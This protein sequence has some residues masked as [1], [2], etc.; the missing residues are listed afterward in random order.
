MVLFFV[1]SNDWEKMV[2]VKEEINFKIMQIVERNGCEFAFPTQT[3]H[4]G[5]SPSSHM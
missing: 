3:I 2:R 1:Y 4:M 5:K